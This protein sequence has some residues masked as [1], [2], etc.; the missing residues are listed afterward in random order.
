MYSLQRKGNIEQKKKRNN[1]EYLN[2]CKRMCHNFKQWTTKSRVRGKKS[3]CKGG[4]KR[5]SGNGKKIGT[6]R[7]VEIENI[8]RIGRKKKKHKIGSKQN[9]LGGGI[10]LMGKLISIECI[11]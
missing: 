11:R 6:G 1:N 7:E 9:I 2:E 5:E 4:E 8:K 10:H 3:Q